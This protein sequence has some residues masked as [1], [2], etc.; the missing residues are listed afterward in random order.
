MTAS[1]LDLSDLDLLDD[2]THHVIC[3]HCVPDYQPGR[4]VLALCG[5]RV[6]SLQQPARL[7]PPNLCRGCADLVDQPCPICLRT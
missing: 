6:V 7:P 1:T 5:R 3:A 4:P 2:P